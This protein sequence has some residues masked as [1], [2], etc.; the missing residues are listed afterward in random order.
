MANAHEMRLH[1]CACAQNHANLLAAIPLGRLRPPLSARYSVFA[2]QSGSCNPEYRCVEQHAQVWCT[3]AASC[4]WIT[5]ASRGATFHEWVWRRVSCIARL[6]RGVSWPLQPCLNQ[7]P[8]VR[9]VGVKNRID[10]NF[11]GRRDVC[12]RVVDEE[13]LPRLN[14]KSLQRAPKERGVGL[15]NSNFVAHHH[16]IKSAQFRD[17]R[18]K[19][20]YVRFVRVADDAHEKIA[21]PFE[22]QRKSQRLIVT[23][24]ARTECANEGILIGCCAGVAAKVGVKHRRV[25]APNAQVGADCIE[26]SADC[27]RVTVPLRAD[28]REPCNRLGVIVANKNTTDVKKDCLH[29]E[30]GVARWNIASP[31]LQSELS[32]RSCSCILS[33]RRALGQLPSDSGQRIQVT[34]RRP[35]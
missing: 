12:L 13:R 23:A 8:C 32:K 6:V 14:A 35:Q 2:N 28:G 10:A 18:I 20:A 5:T 16:E 25:G 21:T 34:C 24:D 31:P 9:P 29:V 27:R 7:R 3:R 17:I 19:P 1:T 30:E 15:G 26:Q 33:P 11:L 4:F 22:F